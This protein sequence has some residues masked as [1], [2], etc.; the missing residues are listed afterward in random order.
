MSY[1]LNL[2]P[3]E[4]FRMSEDAI[5]C[6]VEIV[7]TRMGIPIE[8]VSPSTE[9]HDAEVVLGGEYEHCRVCFAKGSYSVWSFNPFHGEDHIIDGQGWLHDELV[10]AKEISL[11]S[12][13]L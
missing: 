8:S 11:D 4:V 10:K 9:R 1:A 7:V 12:S 6:W 5:R 13:G 2:K 3:N